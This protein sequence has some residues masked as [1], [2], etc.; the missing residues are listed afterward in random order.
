MAK[1][2]NK[3]LFILPAVLLLLLLSAPFAPAGDTSPD[4]DGSAVLYRPTRKAFSDLTPE[5][6]VIRVL[7][8][9]GRTEFFVSNGRPF[10]L[11]YEALAG[12]EKYLNTSRS[13]RSP[14]ISVVFIPM[15]FEDLIP[16]LLQGKGDIAAGLI[17]VTE[18]R[19]AKVTFTAPYVRT[20]DEVLVAYKGAPLPNSIDELAG[21]TVHAVRG[22]SFISHLAAVNQRL[23]A[24]NRPPITVIEMPPSANQDDI[25]EMVNA[26]IFQYTFTD[27]FVAA[28]WSK[29]LPDIRVDSGA[30]LSRGTQIAWAVRP[31]N[32]AL[33]ASLNGFVGYIHDHLQSKAHAV[34]RQY[35]QDTKLIRNPLDLDASERFRQLSPHFREAG[36]K[37]KLYWL[38]MMAQGYQESELD[39]G[40]KSPRGA[41]GVMQLL[42]GT[43]RGIGYHDI[44]TARSNIAAGVA[45]LDFIRNQYFDDPAIPAD[46]RVDF[47]LAAYNAGPGRIQSLRRETAKR[48]LDPNLWFQNVERV[49]LDRIGEETVRYVANINKYYIAYR[50][51]HSLDQEKATSLPASP[52]E[53]AKK[54]TGH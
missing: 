5:T 18:E 43:A 48:G 41:I 40:K 34:W 31:G 27:N 12:Y 36:S 4:T 29:V 30:A 32:P 47:A 44:K 53:S 51:T 9:Y 7:V 6:R 23:A 15:R 35:F 37:N 45:Y 3:A 2:L 24:A 46:A 21:K 22:S 13:R 10:G 16:A 8:H 54:E 52:P 49:A 20:V 28:L 50:M 1:Y 17:T 11:E 19:K 42:P 25:L 33:L 14:K 39:Q 26:G 38:L